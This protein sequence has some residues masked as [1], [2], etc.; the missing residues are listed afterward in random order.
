MLRH[1]HGISFGMLPLRAA[2]AVRNLADIELG[3]PGAHAP[4]P[5]ASPRSRSIS[6]LASKSMVRTCASGREEAR[7]AR[8]GQAPGCFIPPYGAPHLTLARLG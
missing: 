8:P 7:T 3:G 2:E 4:D 6:S 5:A 1:S